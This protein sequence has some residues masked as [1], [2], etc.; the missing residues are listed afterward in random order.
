MVDRIGLMT[1]LAACA[2]AAPASAQGLAANTG[3]W[4]MTTDGG[5]PIQMPQIPADQLAKMTPQQQAMI[6]QGMAA[7]SAMSA[8]P[9][10]RK[11]CVTQ[12][13]LDN[14]YNPDSKNHRCTRTVTTHTSSVLEFAL[15]CPGDHPTTGTVHIEA[16]S[17]E[18]LTGIVDMTLVTKDGASIPIHRTMQGKWLG[19][20]CGDV[21]PPM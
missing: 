3:L 6:Q 20:D 9:I 21:K 18:T 7:A 2:L 10:T 4:E 17:A 8:K 5:A 11:V 12:T 1:A 14:G 15:S 13:M 19:S 16:T